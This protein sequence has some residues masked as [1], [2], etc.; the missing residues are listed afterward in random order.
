MAFYD[1]LVM[2]PW[3]KWNKHNRFPWKPIIHLAVS[4]FSAFVVRLSFLPSFLS[5]NLCL[6][7]ASHPR[8]QVLLY[9][10]EYAAYTRST[11]DTYYLLFVPEGGKILTIND[12]VSSINNSIVTV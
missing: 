5:P 1:K 7:L 3:D 9:V 12:C 11:N 2:S 6:R 10:S 8:L 4:L